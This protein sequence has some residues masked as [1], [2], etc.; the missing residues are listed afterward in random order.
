MDKHYLEGNLCTTQPGIRGSV[1]MALVAFNGRGRPTAA[2]MA[3]PTLLFKVR[4]VGYEMM[5][6]FPFGRI[7]RGSA[8]AA[9]LLMTAHAEISQL[10]V[11][12]VPGNSRRQRIR[13]SGGD[14]AAEIAAVGAPSDQ[15]DVGRAV[16][17]MT[18][19]TGEDVILYRGLVIGEVKGYC[20]IH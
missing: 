8:G 4:M 1:K 18:V 20:S 17:F 6:S 12:I 3:P 10:P 15:G 11:M 2:A 13:Q 14:G 16:R 7:G 5:H 9:V 19:K